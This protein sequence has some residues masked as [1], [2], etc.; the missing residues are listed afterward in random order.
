MRLELGL[1]ELGRGRRRGR[2]A[3]GRRRG[4]R[5]ARR[6]G[7]ARQ[8]SSACA[9]GVGQRVEAPAPPALLAAL[10][11]EPGLG[12]PRRLGVELGVGQRPEVPDAGGRGLLEVVRASPCRARRSGRGRR[13]RWGRGAGLTSA[14]IIR[15]CQN[16][17]K[18]TI[19]EDA[20]H[21]AA[22]RPPPRSRHALGF[23]SL[24][25]EVRVD[26]LPLERRAA[27]VA[28]RLAGAH[29]AGEVGGR[30]ADDE[31]L[32][33]RPGDAAPLRL[34]RTARSPTPAASSRAAPT[35]PRARPAR[36]PTPSSRPTPADRCS[37]G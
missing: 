4:S 20:M 14:A 17:S 35:A 27:R 7:V 33:R 31:P 21:V 12:E 24:E 28:H 18:R 5:R 19:E 22:R 26:S 6:S 3:A 32:V 37:S 2:A 30:R 13:R 9:P 36:S 29:R 8:R 25:S 11:E 15:Y 1:G 34:R 10:V 23:E 16:R